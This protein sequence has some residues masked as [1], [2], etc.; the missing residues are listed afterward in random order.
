[1][2]SK[3]QLLNHA[4]MVGKFGPSDVFIRVERRIMKI[5]TI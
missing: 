1:M 3:I 4:T 2:V 5:L